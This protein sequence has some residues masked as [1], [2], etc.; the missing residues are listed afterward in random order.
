M[1]ITVEMS[2]ELVL[3]DGFLC[4]IWNG[5]A[6]NGVP[7]RVYIHRV[8]VPIDQP[9]GVFDDCLVPMEP[10]GREEQCES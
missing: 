2:D 3:I 9:A 5:H 6:F 8:A 10:P 7:V 1:K 4:R